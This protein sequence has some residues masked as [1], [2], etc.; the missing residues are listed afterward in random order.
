MSRKN[1]VASLNTAD[2]S[3]LNPA[4]ADHIDTHSESSPVG[5]DPASSAQ[6]GGPNVFDAIARMSS[7]G[8]I[9]ALRAIA[10]SAIIVAC[11]NAHDMLIAA[12]DTTDEANDRHELSTSRMVLNVE[13]YSYTCELLNPLAT[14][15][16]D[17]AMT[18]AEALDFASTTA[19]ERAPGD[20]PP[21]VCDALGI[22][23]EQLAVI[24]AAEKQRQIVRNTQLR[25][26][27][28]AH[29]DEIEAEIKAWLRVGEDTTLDGL[30]EKLTPEQHAA[31]FRKVIDKLGQRFNQL[32]AQRAR[33]SG[34][35]GDALLISADRK[36]TDKLYTA[37]V[38]ANE[39]ELRYAA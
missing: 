21:E 19:T 26:S 32:L 31:L 23:P 37:F 35:I 39:S 30:I 38:R 27:L 17:R 12:A 14:T 24:D 29:R 3:V 6:L 33:Y 11:Y 7:V 34:A 15:R 8:Q 1:N 10:N 22:S 4:E 25:E 18:L 36:D 5:L 13:L 28:R 20:L 16:F 9:T 2:R